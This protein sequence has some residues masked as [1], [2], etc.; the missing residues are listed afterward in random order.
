MPRASKRKI[1]SQSP[2]FGPLKYSIFIFR[3]MEEEKHTGL[4]GRGLSLPG[5]GAA[6]PN[7]G[8]ACLADEYRSYSAGLWDGRRLFPET[9]GIPS[10]SLPRIF[11]GQAGLWRAIVRR[12][13]LRE[14][15][16]LCC[17]PLGQ[18]LKRGPAR[19][20]PWLHERCPQTDR[21]FRFSF[22]EA[23]EGKLPNGLPLPDLP[24][25]ST[26]SAH[27]FQVCVGG[28][29]QGGGRGGHGSCL[30]GPGLPQT[31]PPHLSRLFLAGKDS[32][33]LASPSTQFWG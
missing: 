25:A 3:G 32:H 12:R 5:N 9:P 4:Q 29:G 11:L 27:V 6:Q 24:S 22:G 7:S 1:F 18:L 19:L 17:R 28:R 31:A 10:I 16:A 23:E 15:R 26:V 2:F 20:G 13:G 30:L 14:R 8:W 33:S 21:P